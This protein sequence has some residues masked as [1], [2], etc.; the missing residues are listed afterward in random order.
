MSFV[1]IDGNKEMWPASES[2]V[3]NESNEL[4][5]VVVNFTLE[6]TPNFCRD[7]VK[8]GFG[9]LFISQ[10]L[11]KTWFPNITWL[12]DTYHFCSPKKKDSVLAKSFG[13]M[14]WPM[15]SGDMRAAVYAK[16]EELY[17]LK[18]IMP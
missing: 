14:Y 2:F 4:Y 7:S 3:F 8:L 16:T 17:L 13:P 18:R 9:D 6:M 1:I 12:V 5:G 10:D 15:I 11:A